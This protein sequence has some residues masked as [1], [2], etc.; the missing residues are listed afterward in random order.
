VKVYN[1]LTRSKEELVPTTPGEIRMYSC[2]V[3]V[4]D[5]SHVG[6]A[7]MMVVF[8]MISRYLRFAGHRVTFA[9][10][11]TD[12]DDKIIRRANREGVAASEVSERYIAA[13]REDIAALGVEA[14]EVEPKATEHVPEMI[15]LIRRLTDR[16]HTYV[17]DGSVYFRIASFPAYGRLSRLDVSG[18][19]AGARVDTDKYEKDD[20]RDFVLWK[21]KSDEPAWAQWDA[22][23]GRGRPGWHIECSAMAMKYLGETFDLHCG[24]VDLTFP[25]HENE[26]AQSECGTGRPFARHWMHVD[27]LLV[28]GETMSKSR[29]NVYNIPDLLA[30]GFQPAHIRYMLTQAHYR[31]SFNFTWEGMAQ[32]ETAVAR[33]HTFWTRLEEIDSPGPASVDAARIAATGLDAFKRALADDLNTPEALAAVHGLVTDGNALADRGAVT[34]AGAAELLA[35]LESM[36]SVFACFRPAPFASLSADE[37]RLFDERQEARKRRD[38]AAADAARN[39]LLSRGVVIEDTPKGSRWKRV[40]V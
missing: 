3:T 16:G 30:R 22:P 9:R 20:A 25:H 13:F 27:H 24:G 8:D 38:F 26:I 29:G 28:E 23:F 37:Q 1:T 21:L 35:A 31:K 14:P 34:R 6:H 12:I 7:R 2:G 17:S 4:Y 11:F 5:V 18:I 40:R 15:D 10:N 32:V 39:A 19:K 33:V 36:D